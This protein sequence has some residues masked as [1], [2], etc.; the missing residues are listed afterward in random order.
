MNELTI[1][2]GMKSDVPQV[3][4]LVRELAEY[5]K[6]PEQVT[7]TVEDMEAEFDAPNPAF[8]LLVA[9]TGGQVV[10]IAVYFV[11]YST[12]KGRGLYLD[13]IV[14]K[15]SYRGKGI[16]SALFEELLRITRNEGFKQLH[17]QVL[18]WNEPAINF[19]RKYE[20]GFDSEWINCK[21]EE[22]QLN[23]PS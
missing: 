7:N 20:A 9:E 1:R 6:A 3:M 15:E 16:G 5:E 21:L 18:D 13:D 11:K 23:S 8:R 10:G 17:W 12:W 19:Y 14:V 2:E 4:E 22:P